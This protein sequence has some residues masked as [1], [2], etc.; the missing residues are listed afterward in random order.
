MVNY[1]KNTGAALPMVLCC[2]SD[3]YFLLLVT[4]AQDLGN[5]VEDLGVVV[6]TS[7]ELRSG[8]RGKEGYIL[9]GVDTD[10]IADTQSTGLVDSVGCVLRV[11]YVDLEV[12]VRVTLGNGGDTGTIDIDLEVLA[13]GRKTGGTGGQGITDVPIVGEAITVGIDV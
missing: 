1:V 8:A 5:L 12:V 4:Q 7:K 13:V 6:N 3:S 10:G 11:C 9:E 2:L